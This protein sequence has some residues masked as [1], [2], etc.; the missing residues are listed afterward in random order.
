MT[1]PRS[2]AEVPTG[3]RHGDHVC[4]TFSGPDQFA[5]AVVPFLAEGRERG[6]QLLVTGS[7]R[8][9]LREAVRGLPDVDALLATG[10]LELWATAEV[11]AS[12]AELD[13]AAQVRI[14]RDRVDAALA[15]G[16]TGLRVAADISPLAAAPEHRPDLHRFERLADELAGSAALT[17]MCLYD[18]ALGEDVLG[19]LLVLHPVQHHDD[20]PA[21]VHLSGRGPRLSLCGEV[22]CSVAAD[23]LPAL[24]HLARSGPLEAVLDLSALEFLDVAGA[25]ALADAQAALAAAGVTLRLTG[26]RRV[27]T[28]CL[29]LFGPTGVEGVP[30]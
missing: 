2:A 19:P 17:G 25:R 28:R 4:W 26:A 8:D 11:Y 30:A 27:V 14:F 6:E 22:D 13:P 5:G 16:R 20:R 18:A 9:V 3:L 23:V 12:A 7:S 1:A 21:L 29:E 10:Q 24:L 15:A